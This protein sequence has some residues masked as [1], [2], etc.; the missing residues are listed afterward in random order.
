MVIITKYMPATNTKPGRIKA[1]LEDHPSTKVVTE[2]PHHLGVFDSHCEAMRALL[3]KVKPTD[4]NRY[5]PSVSELNAHGCKGG[6]IFMTF[7]EVVKGI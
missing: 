6:Y 3:R 4:P 7:P 5:Y 2:Y 1:Y